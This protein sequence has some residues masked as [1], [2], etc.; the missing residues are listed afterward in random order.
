MRSRRVQATLPA[1]VSRRIAAL[2][3]K[4][5]TRGRKLTRAALLR[6]LLARGLDDLEASNVRPV[7]R[8]SR[9]RL[10]PRNH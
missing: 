5:N 3:A 8:L 1:A 6:M 9:S 10:T 2:L 7:R 4:M